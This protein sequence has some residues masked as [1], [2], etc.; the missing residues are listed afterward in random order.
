MERRA[1][2]RARFGVGRIVE[3][4]TALLVLLMI[5]AASLAGC[6]KTEPGDK[7]TADYKGGARTE[8]ST[9][10]SESNDTR[11]SGS[12]RTGTSAKRGAATE[13]AGG[14]NVVQ[15]SDRGCMNFEPRWASIHVGESVTWRSDLKSPVTIHVAIGAFEHTEFK[16]PAGG[17][18]S[19][20]PARI[21]GSFSIWCDP[22]ACQG[23]PRGAQGSGPGVAVSGN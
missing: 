22:T 6:G 16:V 17:T 7:T 20:G 1:E 14:K 13:H 11:P 5:G 12:N 4:R 8:Q 3:S 10:A 23:A 21:A 9:K 2:S 18:V 15:L 19:S